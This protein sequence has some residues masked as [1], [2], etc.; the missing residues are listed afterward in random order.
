[1]SEKTDVN[2]YIDAHHMLEQKSSNIGEMKQNAV[3]DCGWGK[4]AFGKTFS[5]C[6]TLAQAVIC[7]DDAQR[8]VALY[9]REPHV[10]LSMYPQNLFL[11][12]SHTFRLQLKNHVMDEKQHDALYIRTLKSK[13]EAK[14]ANIIYKARG[15]VPAR[16]GFYMESWKSV[17]HSTFIAIQKDSKKVVGVVMAVDHVEVFGDPDNGSSLWALAVDPQTPA[18]GVGEALVNHVIKHFRRR[19]RS[20][21]DISVMHNNLQAIYLYK[22][23]GFERVQ[24]FCLKNKNPINEPLFIAQQPAENLSPYASIIINEAR[25]RGIAVEVMSSDIGL[26]NLSF[27]GRSIKCLESLSELT[28]APAMSI[29]D[30]KDVSIGILK[31]AGL[32]V[33]EQMLGATVEENTAFLAKHKRLVVKPASGEQGSG[34]SVDISTADELGQAIKKARQQCP[35]VLLEKLVAG[36]DLRIIVIDYAVVAAA[37]RR[38]AAIQGDGAQTVRQLIKRLSRRR[39]AATQG[40]SRIPMDQETAR[41]VEKVGYT[42]NSILPEGVTIPVRKTANLHTGGTIH[43]VTDLL[44][45]ELNQAAVE[46]AQAL[47]IPVTGLDFIIK[48]VTQPDYVIIEANERPGL[49]NH[50]PQPTAERFID[51]LFPQTRAIKAHG[52]R[53]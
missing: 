41:C 12:P 18:P 1:M 11:D 15:M 7:E 38:P 8:N 10:L 33:P 27:G 20:F 5:C 17:A 53:V 47:E 31:R 48:S 50:E 6:E 29:C 25:R 26:F 43:D 46:A 30:R 24:V 19:G 28:T 37:V 22:K 35:T 42:M 23:L 36:D 51:L 9:L 49:A 39:Q 21:L 52:R 13:Q 44:H 2:D 4:L 3:L 32:S 34:I 16:E 45:P 14:Q 40:E